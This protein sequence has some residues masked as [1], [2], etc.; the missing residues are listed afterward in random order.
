M[1]AMGMLQAYVTPSVAAKQ[2]QCHVRTIGR[3]KNHFQQT[4]TTSDR[5]RPGRP[6]C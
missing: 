5:P 6:V 4:S 3:L 2:F 1:H